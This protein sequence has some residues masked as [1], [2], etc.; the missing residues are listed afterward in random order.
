MKDYS[1][2]L[3]SL[4]SKTS[5]GKKNFAALQLQ[6]VKQFFPKETH[7]ARLYKLCAAAL[8]EGEIKLP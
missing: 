1:Q 7:A 2:R 3:T 4:M 6:I 8:T 5:K